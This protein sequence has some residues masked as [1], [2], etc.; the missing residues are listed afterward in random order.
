MSRVFKGKTFT[1]DEI[2]EIDEGKNE[3]LEF[4]DCKLLG[5]KAVDFA[6]TIGW[7]HKVRFDN[8]LLE[9]D[10]DK[11]FSSM[12]WVENSKK[13]DHKIVD[14]VNDKVIEEDN[15]LKNAL[16]SLP[17]YNME[18]TTGG[19]VLNLD[20]NESG[21]KRSIEVSEESVLNLLRNNSDKVGKYQ[22]TRVKATG[23]Y[24]TDEGLVYL[25]QSELDKFE[26]YRMDWGDNGS[27]ITIMEQDG[28]TNI[29]LHVDGEHK[30][31]VC[32]DIPFDKIEQVLPLDANLVEEKL[33]S[34]NYGEFYGITEQPS[35]VSHR[36]LNVNAW[37]YNRL[38]LEGQSVDV[39]LSG[40]VLDYNE[41][42]DLD[43]DMS[44]RNLKLNSFNHNTT[45]SGELSGEC[46]FENYLNINLERDLDVSKVNNLFDAFHGD[47]SI[48]NSAMLSIQQ[49]E[50]LND[51]ANYEIA[52]ESEN[53]LCKP[54]ESERERLLEV[55]M[56]N[57]NMSY[58]GTV[59]YSGRE[60]LLAFEVEEGLMVYQ[61]STL[62]PLKGGDGEF[63]MIDKEEMDYYIKQE[64]EEPK[65]EK[66]SRNRMRR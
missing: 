56:D 16:T 62:K 52:S 54:L 51:V 11:F 19:I 33:K 45:L 14:A 29:D 63:F 8:C 4:I 43:I 26:Y 28:S 22:D 57:F 34:V 40:A 18:S 39:E 66:K 49:I 37:L 53:V 7:E 13:I 30:G 64:V 38:S 46:Y 6:D 48:F 60:Q 10:L 59:D 15:A 36:E 24:P 9:N 20:L 47:C 65:Q 27:S 5:V 17:L 58:R 44:V 55:D 21:V 23:E 31:S 35:A 50:D 3:D 12:G 32:L 61:E 25:S 1:R 2:R 41:A 42:T